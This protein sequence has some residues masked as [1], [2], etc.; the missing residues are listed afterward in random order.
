MKA[1]YWFLAWVI[2]VF[3]MWVGHNYNLS[4]I[5]PDY[6]IDSI[7]FLFSSFFSFI[8]GI[9]F[10][11]RVVAKLKAVPLESPKGEP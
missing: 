9:G 10:Y 8:F 1:R 11:E 3:S 6:T 2:T 5:F 7:L 4:R